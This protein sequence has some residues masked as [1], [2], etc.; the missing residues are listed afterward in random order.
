VVWLSLLVKGI[1]KEE[2]RDAILTDGVRFAG[3]NIDM[4]VSEAG[5]SEAQIRD[6]ILSDATP[7]AGANIDMKISQAG[8]KVEL[9]AHGTLV[10]DGAGRG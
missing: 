5:V 1:S 2:V 4:K 7:F 3:A 8:V 9:A 6:A 10:A